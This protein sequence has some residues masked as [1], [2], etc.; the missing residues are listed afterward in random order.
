MVLLFQGLCQRNQTTWLLFGP[1][2]FQCQSLETKKY[3]R[4]SLEI[5]K[6]LE[7]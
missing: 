2:F 3:F 1:L 5:K 7:I 6:Y 4:K